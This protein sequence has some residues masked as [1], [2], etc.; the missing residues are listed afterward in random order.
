M[1]HVPRAGNTDAPS[2][3]PAHGQGKGKQPKA[4]AA[5]VQQCKGK[6]PKDEKREV[7]RS[8]VMAEYV[9]AGSY[10]PS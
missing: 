6:Q 10:L 7:L 4:R 2:S 9:Q 5:G 8:A 1:L 3:L